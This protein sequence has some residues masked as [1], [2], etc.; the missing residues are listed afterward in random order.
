MVHNRMIPRRRSVGLCQG[1]VNRMRPS[2]LLIDQVLHGYDRGHKELASSIDLDSHSRSTMLVMS[3][4]MAALE[5]KEGQSYLVSYPLR[6]AAKHVLA[7]TWSAGR[8]YRPGSVWTHSIILDYQA[9]T[10][11]SDLMLLRDLFRYPEDGGVD[12]DFISPIFFRSETTKKINIDDDLR[13][14]SALTQL[15]GKTT[16]SNIV[17]PYA[18]G[19]KN[20]LL[21]LSLWRQMWPGL[22]REFTFVT[23]PLDFLTGIDTACSLRFSKRESDFYNVENSVVHD[24]H[25]AL[26]KDLPYP[27]TTNLRTFLGRYVIESK[28]PKELA[29]KLAQLQTEIKEAPIGLRLKRVCKLARDANLS[30]LMRD[31]FMAELKAAEDAKD[32][33]NI[34]YIFRD[35]IIDV[36]GG[37]ILPSDMSFADEDFRPALFSVMN[38]LEGSIGRVVFCELV[39]I[40]NLGSLVEIAGDDNRLVMIQLRPE[41]ILVKGFWPI[42][43]EGRA[44]V[45][46]ELEDKVKVSTKELFEVFGIDIGLQTIIAIQSVSPELPSFGVMRLL[47]RGSEEVKNYLARWAIST[48]GFLSKVS[49]NS[50]EL[51]P[52]VVDLLARA[53]IDSGRNIESS[54]AWS[55]LLFDSVFSDLNY[56]MSGAVIIVGF[57][58]GVSGGGRD[59][60]LLR[61][62]YDPL[63]KLIKKQISSQDE[64]YLRARLTYYPGGRALHSLVASNALKALSPSLYFDPRVFN[65]SQVP[66]NLAEIAREVEARYGLDAMEK[67]L[68]NGNVADSARRTVELHIKNALHKK[69]L[70][71]WW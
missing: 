25:L 4:S 46:G 53:Q 28:H 69:K 58:L 9:L 21:A 68:N 67:A 40:A 6:S 48:P 19:E 35:E 14:L 55:S 42:S 30:R 60:V 65:I 29:P 7:R 51:T 34:M 16:R 37:G 12:H 17:L 45:I 41:L 49:E 62:F 8:G 52:A 22:R 38:S 70:W 66:E 32:L 47:S 3:D 27:G 33:I 50:S 26:L 36:G 39:A 31:A 56:K 18:S 15:Y 24:G 1:S 10:L 5:M 59:S 57:I 2:S 13:A 71:T 54:E 64:N 23:C 44:K 20:E 43:D 11:I 61:K 63:Q